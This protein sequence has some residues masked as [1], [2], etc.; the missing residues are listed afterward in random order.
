MSK[1]KTLLNFVKPEPKRVLLYL[2][3]LF[4]IL[5][6]WF[7]VFWQDST[8]SYILTVYR[9]LSNSST[10]VNPQS[11]QPTQTELNNAD[12]KI[13]LKILPLDQ[14]SL[15]MN[16]VVPRYALY[17]LSVYDIYGCPISSFTIIQAFVGQAALYIAACIIVS[18]FEILK[19]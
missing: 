14:A 11:T 16:L 17:C 15:S 2:L 1:A 12:A 6:A 5:T 8:A 18:L 10:S 4:V 13:L 19:R 7:Y 9:F 3:L